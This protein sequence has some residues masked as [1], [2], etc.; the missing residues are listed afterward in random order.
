MSGDFLPFGGNAVMASRR[1]TGDDTR[2]YFPTPMWAARA[3]GEIAKRLFPAATSV[4][5]PACGGG[6]MAHGLADFFDQVRRTDLYDYGGDLP[7]LDF[8]SAEADDLEPVD[9]DRHQPALQ[10]RRGLHPHGLARARRGVAMLLRLQFIEGGGAARAVHPRLSADPVR[11]VLRAG[12]D[13]R[14]PLGSGGLERDGLWLVRVPQAGGRGGEP[15]GR[16]R[17]PRRGRPAAPWCGRSARGPRPGCTATPTRRYRVPR[18]RR[19]VAFVW[20]AA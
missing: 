13:G 14:R 18:R 5:E 11:A 7:L 19:R 6:H 12:A 9:L 15:A 20:V 4:W 10:A 2:D 16:R 17:S 3:G 8:L 1:S